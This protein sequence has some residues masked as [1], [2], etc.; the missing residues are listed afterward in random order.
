[1]FNERAVWRHRQIGPA[2][3]ECADLVAAICDRH[4]CAAL[5][6]LEHDEGGIDEQDSVGSGG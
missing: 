4:L 1:M 2:G 3:L 6:S 5:I